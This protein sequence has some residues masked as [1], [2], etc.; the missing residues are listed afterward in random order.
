M[1][2]VQN[3]LRQLSGTPAQTHTEAADLKAAIEADQK[4]EV[5]QV[6][7]ELTPKETELS[8]VTETYRTFSQ[9]PLAAARI[10]NEPLDPSFPGYFK[11]PGTSTLLRIG[12]YAKT[13]FIYDLKP[14][15]NLDSFIPATIPIPAPATYTN[16]TVSV[17]PTL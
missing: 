1:V 13:D 11:L 6:E 5:T 8:K 2:E 3:E 14:A 9:D 4:Q 12:G 17:R 7:T 10:N 15:G 16:S